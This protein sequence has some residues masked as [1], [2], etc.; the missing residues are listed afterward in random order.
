MPTNLS[1]SERLQLLRHRF[2]E[3]GHLSEAEERLLAEVAQ[4][5]ARLE[6]APQ[7][8][9][10]TSVVSMTTGEARLDVTFHGQVAQVDPVKGREM[11]WMLLEGASIA[12]AEAMLVRFSRQKFGITEGQATALLNDLRSFRGELAN[13]GSLVGH[14][15]TM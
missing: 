12:E 10:V 9:S 7:E 13:Q 14:K 3:A 4:I 5:S 2:G 15:R 1:R 11:A 6:A 8:F